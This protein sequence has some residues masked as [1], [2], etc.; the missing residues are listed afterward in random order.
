MAEHAIGALG[1]NETTWE[2]FT[3]VPASVL[4]PERTLLEKLALLHDGAR[5]F[6]DG[7]ARS[8]LLQGGRHL[9]DV[10][11]LLGAESVCGALRA[12]GPDGVQALWSDIDEH[13][14]DA[15]FSFTPRPDAG[16]GA[17]PLLDAWSSSSKSS[18][19]TRRDRLPVSGRSPRG[20]AART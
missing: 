18:L 8:K 13:S 20:W 2:E 7:Q 6:P 10:Y 9:Y 1:D 17:S 14:E 19:R 4:A 5:R 3:A 12:H 11:Q 16:F 15:E